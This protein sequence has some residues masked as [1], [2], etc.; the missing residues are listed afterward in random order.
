MNKRKRPAAI[1]GLSLFIAL[2]TLMSGLAALALATPG[3]PLEIIWRVN[4]AAREGFTSIGIWAV[5][6]M[7]VVSVGCGVAA[8]GLWKLRPWA[9]R[10]YQ[11]SRHQHDW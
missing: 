10:R 11:R 5:G 3:G 8:Y 9:L 1:T 7:M 6:L 4:P 2:G